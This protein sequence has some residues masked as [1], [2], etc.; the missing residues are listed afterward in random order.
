[1]VVQEAMPKNDAVRGEVPTK[2]SFGGFIAS[3]GKTPFSVADASFLL[4]PAAGISAKK[5]VTA[6]GEC[7]TNAP[8][9]VGLKPREWYGKFA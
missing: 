5:R 3:V 9:I 1:M 6:K 7:G 8:V 4:F 2:Q